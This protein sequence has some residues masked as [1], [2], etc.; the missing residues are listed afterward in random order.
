[1][2]VVATGEPVPVQHGQDV[3]E[4]VQAYPVVAHAP[5]LPW[6]WRAGE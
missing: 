3:V 1:V 4:Q 2:L 6:R 5:F